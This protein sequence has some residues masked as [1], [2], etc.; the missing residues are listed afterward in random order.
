M[1]SR[2]IIERSWYAALR[3]C[4]SLWV[5]PDVLPEQPQELINSERPICYVLE[6]GSLADFLALQI[7]C[8]R[9]GIPT[10]FRHSGLLDWG[11]SETLADV[12]P[13]VA[14]RRGRGL[15]LRRS[16]PQLKRLQAV[17]E[18][19]DLETMLFLPVAIYWGRSPDKEHSFIKVLFSEHWDVA[20]R[21]RK[22]LTTLIHGRNTLVRF[23]EPLDVSALREEPRES[24]G[25]SESKSEASSHNPERLTRKLSR[26]LR[27]H[28]R[29]RRIASLG[30]DQS[31]KR[32]IINTVL[33]N[34]AV[35]EVIAQER[36]KQEKNPSK[37]RWW[38]SQPQAPKDKALGYA[39]E[40]AA[41]MSFSTVR[42]L[43]LLLQ[44][45]WNRL[46]DGV[47]FNGLERLRAINDGKEVVYVPCHRSH[48]DYLLMSYALYMQGFSLPHIAAGLN[49][50][51]P[52]IGPILRRGGAFF[53]RRSFSGNRLYAAVFNAY[54]QEI[55]ARG[56]SMEYFIEGGRSRSGRLLPPKAGMLVMTV[57]AYLKDTGRPIVFVPIYFGYERMVEGQ[58]FISELSGGKKEKES[59]FGFFGSLRALRQEFGEVY[60]NVG[61]PLEL[62]QLLDEH[63]PQWRKNAD[64]FAVPERPDWLPPLIDS[65]GQEIMQ[66]INRAASVTPVAALAT[67]LLGAPRLNMAY[68]DLLQQLELLLSLLKKM[69]YSE[70]LSLPT[71]S[72][73]EIVLHGESLGYIEREKHA[74]GDL[75][76]LKPD[77]AVAMTY[78]RN[79]VLHLFAVPATVAACFVNR[80]ALK[81]EEILRL[82]Q[83]GYPYLRTELFLRWNNE[84]LE[85]IVEQSLSLFNDMGLLDQQGDVYTR[86]TGNSS[87]TVQLM[88]LAQS[89]MPALQ[90][91]YMTAVLL[92]RQGSGTLSQKD[93]EKLCE[94]CAERLTIMHGLRS[95]DFFEK[96]LFRSFIKT[97]KEMKLLRTDDDGLLHFE[98]NFSDVEHQASLLLD[99]QIRHSIKSI[100][101]A[102]NIEAALEKTS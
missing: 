68:S 8:R 79:N 43:Q 27:V 51:M 41:D 22:F 38:Q 16:H 29:Q 11:K 74:L 82:I 75:V 94:L 32:T 5:R 66:R 10:P 61:A 35:R 24:E 67:A 97:L 95:P 56:H 21:S 7:V 33:A 34:E 101:D 50:N 59:L 45:F 90:R 9:H 26:I 25:D 53:L 13:V 49:L 69:P 36:S 64:A 76:Q 62:D 23:S 91:Y 73:E 15:I 20:S 44:A 100:T 14:I 88:L 85:Q 86:N 28:F 3:A 81:R 1:S 18:S 87:A 42:I 99:D 6:T 77:Q 57:Q 84:E 37:K 63:H 92:S 71:H 12:A 46:Y 78:F 102:G 31:H 93:L 30:P 48:I 17:L 80:D 58:S 40:I 96:N 89:T 19:G 65:L 52:V 54:V 4:T 83:L 70:E 2:R 55:I 39:Y 60:A 98:A 72:A 47:R